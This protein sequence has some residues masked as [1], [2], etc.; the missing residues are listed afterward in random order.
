MLMKSRIARYIDD[1]DGQFRVD[2]AVYLDEEIFAA[3]IEHLFEGGWVYLAH[4][5]QIREPGDYFST[6]IGRQPVF[7]V[8]KKDGGIGGYLEASTLG[9]M[10]TYLESNTFTNVWPWDVCAAFGYA[11]VRGGWWHWGFAAALVVFF[12]AK[13]RFEEAWLCVR[14]PDYADYR[15]HTG[16][17]WP[18][19]RNRDR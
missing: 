2:R 9:S 16:M 13:I 8:R 14:Y 6:R 4:E 11:C 5:S 3:E 10:V 7:V 17:L 15:A 1:R 12:V 18:R 19:L